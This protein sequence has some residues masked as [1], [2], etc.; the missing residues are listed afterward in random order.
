MYCPSLLFQQVFGVLHSGRFWQL[1][2]LLSPSVWFQTRV[3]YHNVHWCAEGSYFFLSC[4]WF[5]CVWLPSKA[6]DT[7]DHTLLLEKF[8]EKEL[9][10]LCGSIFAHMVSDATFEGE[11]EWCS[12]WCISCFVRS[13][14]GECNFSHSVRSVYWWFALWTWTV[15]GWLFL[16]WPVCGCTHLCWWPCLVSSKSCCS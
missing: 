15:W 11:L 6:F 5:L 7:V 8:T 10:Y 1:F 4:R 13:P 16:G 2:A 9:A 14:T 12:I 3:V